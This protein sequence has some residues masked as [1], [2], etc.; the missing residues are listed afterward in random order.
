M[1][2]TFYIWLIILIITTIYRNIYEFRKAKG[3]I[4]KSKLSFTILF[5]DMFLLWSSWFAM[6]E[7]DIIKI[8]MPAILR[9]TGI[10]LTILGIFLFLVAWYTTKSLENYEGGL[11]TT[12]I[13]SFTRHPMYLGF[14]CWLVGF[15]LFQQALV[16]LCIAPILILSVLY[17]KKVEEKRL[18]KQFQNNYIEYKKKTIF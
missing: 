10:V 13:Y 8:E 1:K 12:G 5:A 2:N 17:W 3:V 18:I 6:C 4:A 7:G 15:P 11:I 16:S 14:I 9:I